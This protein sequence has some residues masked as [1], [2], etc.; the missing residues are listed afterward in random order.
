MLMKRRRA[1]SRQRFADDG[2]ESDREFEFG[3]VV[4]HR[5]AQDRAANAIPSLSLSVLG[6]DF[7]QGFARCDDVILGTFRKYIR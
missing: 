2:E 1:K 7:L 4:G 5:M 3:P 6:G